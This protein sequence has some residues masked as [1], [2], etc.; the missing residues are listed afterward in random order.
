M[1]DYLT[2]SQEQLEWVR[3]RLEALDK[4]ETKLKAMRELAAYA[5]NH[6]LSKKEADR[7][8]E[9]VNI[10]QEEINELGKTSDLRQRNLSDPN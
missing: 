10:L 9:W 8:Q 3:C 6:A 7:V 1:L 5:A 2:I 4:I